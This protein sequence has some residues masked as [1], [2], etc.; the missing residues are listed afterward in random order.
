MKSSDSNGLAYNNRGEVYRALQNY[1]QAEKDYQSAVQ[2][3]WYGAYYNLGYTYFLM[4]KPYHS[5]HAY[6][7]GFF[8]DKNVFL[9]I[10]S[11]SIR[12]ILSGRF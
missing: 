9:V 10:E 11:L 2:L 6:L 8:T 5:V 1:E 12:D 7:Q 4:N 3:S